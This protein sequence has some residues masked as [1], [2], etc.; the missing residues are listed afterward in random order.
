MPNV[1]RAVRI[2]GHT[3]KEVRM[4]ATYVT[5]GFLLLLAAACQPGGVGDPCD[6]ISCPSP[7]PD[8][9]PPGWLRCD[10]EEEE[11]YLEG[12]SLQCRTRVCMVFRI[13]KNYQDPL[14]TS[15]I[16]GPYCTRPCGPGATYEECP[17]GYCCMSVVTSG[18]SQAAGFYCVEKDDLTKSTGYITGED[19]ELIYK[20]YKAGAVEGNVKAYT[21]DE[22][23]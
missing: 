12:R 1:A 18:E 17:A 16:Q 10:W 20:C 19:C 3:L 15:E 9:S 21:P 5:L 6:P 11:I 2:F 4:K 7:D 23:P 13:D 14:L 8:N 22:C